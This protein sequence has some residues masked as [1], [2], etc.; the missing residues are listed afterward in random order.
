M[1]TQPYVGGYDLPCEFFFLG[2]NLRFDPGHLGAWISHSESHFVNAP[3]PTTAICTF[4]DEATFRSDGD[5]VTNWRDRMLHIFD[6]LAAFTPSDQM[7]PDFWVIEHMQKYGLISSE[8]H[9]HSEQGTE[10]P[11]SDNMYPLDWKPQ[12]ML[13]REDREVQQP[14]DMGKE[15][16]QMDREK[17]KSTHKTS[18]SHRP[19]KSQ[20]EVTVR[21]A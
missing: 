16:R 9:A 20:R 10:R 14:Y 13:D 8:D 19:R 2:C 21:T 12:D 18:S 4:C 5:A 1:A 11:H 17:G 7:R 6:H 3:L 15:R